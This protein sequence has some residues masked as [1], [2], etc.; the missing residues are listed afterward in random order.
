MR[1]V[2]KDNNNTS[3]VV[4]GGHQYL[5]AIFGAA[6]ENMVGHVMLWV[7]KVVIIV[8]ECSSDFDR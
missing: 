8:N 2:F 3:F 6:C 5:L 4:L 7:S 1:V